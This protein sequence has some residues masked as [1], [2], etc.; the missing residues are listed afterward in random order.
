MTRYVAQRAEELRDL[1]ASLLPKLVDE[2]A[3][4][5]VTVTRVAIRRGSR[6]A[7]VYLTIFPATSAPVVLENIQQHL[8]ELQGTVNRSFAH[9]PAP[10]LSFRLEDPAWGTPPIS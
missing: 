4:V 8:Y 2:P 9:H 3:D 1:V 5:L 10:R 7:T 6:A